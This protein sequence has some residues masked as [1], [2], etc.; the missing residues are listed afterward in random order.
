[1]I[2]EAF[3][4]EDMTKFIRPKRFSCR[5]EATQTP[6][7]GLGRQR[8]DETTPPSRA[9][10]STHPTLEQSK[11][12]IWTVSSQ[13][14]QRLAAHGTGAGAA[15]A[16]PRRGHL[17]PPRTNAAMSGRLAKGIPKSRRMPGSLP[18]SL[19]GF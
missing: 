17:G 13:H 2:M 16:E 5:T 8:P 11:G 18:E 19:F 12:L 10:W 6:E 15:N 3:P 4:P 14:F 9:G 7:R 1:M